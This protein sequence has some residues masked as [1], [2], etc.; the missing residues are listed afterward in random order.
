MVESPEQVQ[1]ATAAILTAIGLPAPVP[2][3][4]TV[5]EKSYPLA[6]LGFPEINTL[7]IWAKTTMPDPLE[8][9]TAHLTGLPASIQR[10]M[11]ESALAAVRLPVTFGS[12]EFNGAM[13]TQQ[14]LREVLWL[15]LKRAGAGEELTREASDAAADAM[16]VSAA[17]QTFKVALLGGV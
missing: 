6:R 5:G 12:D 11:V 9:V 14:G 10:V 16:G 13:Q 17:T 15:S 7:R 2:F 4:V 3:T 8:A 1:Q